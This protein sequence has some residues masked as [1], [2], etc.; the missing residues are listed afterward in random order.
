[1]HIFTQ[2]EKLQMLASLSPIVNTE[3]YLCYYLLFFILKYRLNIYSTG[4]Q[5]AM[6]G[7]M[8]I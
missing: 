2:K 6:D 5:L 1:M 4:M 8:T 3:H 7:L